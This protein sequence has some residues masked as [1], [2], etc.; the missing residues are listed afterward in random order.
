MD[1]PAIVSVILTKLNGSIEV[2]RTQGLTGLKY[3]DGAISAN[4]Y[5]HFYLSG[6]GRVLIEKPLELFD[7]LIVFSAVHLFK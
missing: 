3:F 4:R 6:D 2:Q 1:R 5:I 7:D